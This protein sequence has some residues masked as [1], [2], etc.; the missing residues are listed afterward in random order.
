[1]NVGLINAPQCPPFNTNYVTV[2]WDG[3]NLELCPPHFAMF[4]QFVL[5]N[6][7]GIIGVFFENFSN[8]MNDQETHNV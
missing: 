5:R 4:S 7:G 1:M 2:F 8:H 6:V 3:Q